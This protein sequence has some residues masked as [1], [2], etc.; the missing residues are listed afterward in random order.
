MRNVRF[1]LAASLVCTLF[2]LSATRA[3]AADWLENCGT[4]VVSSLTPRN[5]AC[6][7]AASTNDD[8]GV[9]TVRD[10]EN[11]DVL[12]FTDTDGNGTA[13]TLTVAL[14]SCPGTTA[15]PD[16]CWIVEGLTL[17]GSAPAEAIYGLGA[18]RVYA[19]VSATGTV[20]DPTL[21]VRC[22]GPVHP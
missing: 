19:D 11:V 18:E 20:A 22:N 1:I 15:D 8:S 12:Y 9:L 5:S 7:S 2:A 16:A 10:C 21:I 4:R 14:R 17:T 6:Y 13:S 3:R